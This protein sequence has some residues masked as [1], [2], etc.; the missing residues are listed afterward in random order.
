MSC[1]WDGILRNLNQDDFDI[2]SSNKNINNINFILLLK[3]KN[4]NCDNV[5]WQN[6]LIRKTLLE[7]N[8]KMINEFNEKNVNNGY[9]CSSCDPFLILIC[10]IFKLTIKHDYN[11]HKIEYKYNINSR[12]VINFK[13]NRS[14]F[15]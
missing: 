14:H 1:F 12:K 10:E 5:L 7:E 4:I 13:S 11:G 2:I 3:N 6:E 8:Y 15:F 9:D